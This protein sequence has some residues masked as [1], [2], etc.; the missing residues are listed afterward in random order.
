MEEDLQ[1]GGLYDMFKA[2]AEQLGVDA[3][4][5]AIKALVETFERTSASILSRA[6]SHLRPPRALTA[7]ETATMPQGTFVM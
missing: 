7:M 1:S 5:S 4:D 6:V 2:R 3:D